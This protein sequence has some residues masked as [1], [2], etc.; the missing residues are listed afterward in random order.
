VFL[1]KGDKAYVR[2]DLKD[3]SAFQVFRPARR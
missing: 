2:G 3:N 1:G